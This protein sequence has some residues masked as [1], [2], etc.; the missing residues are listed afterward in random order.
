MIELRWKEVPTNEATTNAIAI[1]GQTFNRYLVLQ[2]RETPRGVIPPIKANW[3]D[4]P[5][6]KEHQ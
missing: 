3:S 5:I 2:F 1:Q 6:V 4:V